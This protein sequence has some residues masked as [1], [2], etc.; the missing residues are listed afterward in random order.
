MQTNL[1]DER[2]E[3]K[4]INKIK[5]K[6]L[7]IFLKNLLRQPYLEMDKYSI[8]NTEFSIFNLRKKEKKLLIIITVLIY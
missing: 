6:E 5:C 4:N 8:F 2:I 7:I 3:R 1:I